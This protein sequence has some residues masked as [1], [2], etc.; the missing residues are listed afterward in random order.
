MGKKIHIWATSFFRNYVGI[1]S[2]N[3]TFIK[4][5]G[6]ILKS[7]LKAENTAMN[8]LERLEKHISLAEEEEFIASK[9]DA[10]FNASTG[11]IY[12][13]IFSG[14]LWLAIFLLLKFLL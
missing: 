2:L 7:F 3:L 14:Y 6:K 11:F 13:L 12:G 9:D 1:T 10:S 5:S 4:I 8:N